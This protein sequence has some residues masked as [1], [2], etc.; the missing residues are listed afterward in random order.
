ML[1]HSLIKSAGRLWKYRTAFCTWIKVILIQSKLK[2][3]IFINV[4]NASCLFESKAVS[5]N[6]II[7]L[8]HGKI[9]KFG[10]LHKS[11]MQ[12]CL[13]A[14]RLLKAFQ[15]RW[16]KVFPNVGCFVNTTEESPNARS[17]LNLRCGSAL[18]NDISFSECF[19][20]TI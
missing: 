20:P 7:H 12:L 2:K 9:L 1:S 18:S 3:T 19:F 11:Y 17:F 4:S 10:N 8:N 14:T 16:V 5:I 13:N 6:A 15:S